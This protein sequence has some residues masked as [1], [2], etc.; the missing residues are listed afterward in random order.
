VALACAAAAP[1]AASGPRLTDSA[2][3][4][5]D[6][7]N[8]RSMTW[9]PSTGHRWPSMRGSQELPRRW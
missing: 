1:A 6:P 7:I 3:S 8:H 4:L 5:K 2:V 9:P